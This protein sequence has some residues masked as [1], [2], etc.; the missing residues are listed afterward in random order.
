MSGRR[1]ENR[2]NQRGVHN[3]SRDSLF[4]LGKGSDETVA[5]AWEGFDVDGGIGGII[6]GFAEFIDG[7]VEA[8]V[9]I[10]EGVAGPETGAKFFPGD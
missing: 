8:M 6:E 10:N 7:G 3:G 5:A 4:E 9:E 1:R 2:L